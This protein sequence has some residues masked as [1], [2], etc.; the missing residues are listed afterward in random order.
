MAKHD[1]LRPPLGKPS[2]YAAAKTTMPGTKPGMT[3][4]K[5]DVYLA[6]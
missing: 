6:F 3:A 5:C 2:V 4:N 1:D